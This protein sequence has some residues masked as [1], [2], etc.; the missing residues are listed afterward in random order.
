MIR[1]PTVS[2]LYLP[3]PGS[4]SCDASPGLNDPPFGAK[5]CASI[6]LA[7]WCSKPN[8]SYPVPSPMDSG[9]RTGAS[10]WANSKR[11]WAGTPSAEFEQTQP[12]LH[13]SNQSGLERS[14][15]VCRSLIKGVDLSVIMA[16]ARGKHKRK[17]RERITPCVRMN[18]GTLRRP[19]ARIS[20][21]SP[22]GHC[23]EG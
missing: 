4:P 17:N 2:E 8:R 13:F 9:T 16:G 23:G 11:A 1:P 12:P 6:S 19:L 15:P 20:S 21:T 3:S 14:G 10:P 5:R 22:T 18:P 7:H